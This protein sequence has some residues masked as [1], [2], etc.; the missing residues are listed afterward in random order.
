[1]VEM[2]KRF[3]EV[4]SLGIVDIECE[5]ELVKWKEEVVFKGCYY[6]V[7]LLWKEGCFF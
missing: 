5:V 4:E 2:L 7:G 3:W 1:M 6:E